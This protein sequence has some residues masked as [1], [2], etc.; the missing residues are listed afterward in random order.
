MPGSR[1]AGA[2]QG[3]AARHGRPYTVG[4]LRALL[5]DA[6][7]R[8]QLEICGAVV[9]RGRLVLIDEREFFGWETRHGRRRKKR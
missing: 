9:R 6:T 4:A 7:T 8:R 5:R 3:F 2:V 1:P